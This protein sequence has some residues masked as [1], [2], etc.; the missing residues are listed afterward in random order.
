MRTFLFVLGIAALAAPA[1][2]ASRNFGITSFEKVRVDGPFKVSLKT[3]VAPFARATGSPQALD[4][5]AIDVRGNTLV[6]HTNLDSWGGYPGKDPGPVEISLGTHDLSAAWLNGS[7]VLSIDKVKGLTFDLSVQGSGA[8][9]IGQANIDQLNV[10]VVGT[11]SAKLAG[12]AAKMTAVIRGVSTLDAAAL[13]TKDATLG[14]DGAATIAANVSNS[15]TVDASGPA[16]IRL[17]GGPSCTLRVS[18]SA[19]VSGCR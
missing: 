6:V 16:T 3:G 14:A 15:V 18:G 4:R 10:S 2:A 8:G 9:E 17:S 5:V 7:G 11:A 12:Q 19:S 13:S 1:G